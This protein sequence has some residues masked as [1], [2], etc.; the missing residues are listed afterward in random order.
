LAVDASCESMLK[1]NKIHGCHTVKLVPDSNAT[2]QNF[3]RI[4]KI[5]TVSVTFINRT[6]FDLYIQEQR[7]FQ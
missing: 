2:L 6:I 7:T 3:K 1:I 5:L 4:M